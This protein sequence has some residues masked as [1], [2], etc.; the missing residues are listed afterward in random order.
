VKSEAASD[1]VSDPVS[2]DTAWISLGSNMG[3]RG[4]NL[5]RLREALT[6][7]GVAITAA[8][9]EILTRPVG[10]TAQGDFHNQVVRLHSPAPWSPARW[11]Q[12]V[13]AA[14]ITAGRRP[15]YRWGP[16]IADADILLL[17][18]HGEIEVAEPG[19]TVPHPEI[20]D[21]PFEGALLTEAGFAPETKPGERAS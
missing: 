5:K 7:N 12:H 1:P 3:N 16:R 10:V 14:E 21:R 6:I 13:Q 9:S 18:E 8:S 20:A 15:T 2:T 11:L 19:L 17:G 4:R